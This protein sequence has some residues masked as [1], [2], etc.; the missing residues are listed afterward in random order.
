M[1]E[2]KVELGGGTKPR[3]GFTNVDRLD[4]ADVVLDLADPG[5]RLPWEDDEVD[6]VYSSHCLEHLPAYG[7]VLLEVARICR[8]GARVE[9]RVPHPHS[10]MAM[11]GGHCHVLGEDAVAQWREFPE[12]WWPTGSKWLSAPAVSL[13]PTKW[14]AEAKR[15]HP[16]WTDDQVMRFVPSA[17][18]DTTFVFFVEVKPR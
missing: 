7:H 6:E 15:L 11:C 3:E 1:A 18:H 10:Q 8:V 12:C 17:C 13:G 5:L 4:C 16:G 14:F 2:V 9:I